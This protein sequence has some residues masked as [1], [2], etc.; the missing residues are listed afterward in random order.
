MESDSSSLNV[1][2]ATCRISI[3]ALR[4]ESD[5]RPIICFTQLRISIHALR[6][7]SDTFFL[8]ISP[9]NKQFLSTLSAW[10]A[11]YWYAPVGGRC[12]ISIHALRME[13]DCGIPVIFATRAIS[14]HALR[15]E[16]DATMPLSA[17][18]REEFLSTLSAWRATKVH[19]TK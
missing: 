17:P 7:E 16:S 3:H 12:T 1:P 8:I 10:R 4:M 19:A 15:M 13:S 11:T 14:I 6:M 18:G 2:N 5:H 9:P